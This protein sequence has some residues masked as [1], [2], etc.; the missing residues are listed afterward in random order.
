MTNRIWLG[1]AV[2]ILFLGLLLWRVDPGEVLDSL[3]KANYVYLVPGIV[4]YFTVALAFRTVRWRLLLLALRPIPIGRL[5]PVVVVGYMANNL[6]PLRLGELV[7]SHYLGQREGVSK[8][9]ALTT[10]AV[11]RVVDG[12]VLLFLLVVMAF[13]LPMTGMV[14][15]LARDTGIPL[16]LLVTGA[17]TP[18]V[19]ILALLILAA[20]NPAWFLRV[21]SGL[22]KLMPDYAREKVMELADKAV[23]G[24]SVLRNPRQMGMMFL[25]SLPVWLGEAAMYY[26]IGFSFGLDDALGG[27]WTMV[28]AIIAVTATS[29]LATAVPASQGSIGPF[30]LFATGTLV[31]LGVSAE[32]A[33]AYAL[34][35]H[36]ALLVPVTLAGLVYLWAGKDSLG[37]LVRMSGKPGD[38]SPDHRQ[39]GGSPE[40]Q[41]AEVREAS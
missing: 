8:T 41:E 9:A 30:E 7:R 29:N 14:E 40:L 20:R 36:V 13:F 18:F 4:L 31:V 5:L 35:L 12:V 38:A 27:A 39:N 26:V 6:L 17:T 19:G 28:P 11:E 2:S 10:I 32:T 33:A 3:R 25:L 22:A 23:T 24:L 16:P 1:L 15:G 21:V 37:Q 34:T